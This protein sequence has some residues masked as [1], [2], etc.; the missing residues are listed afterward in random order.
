[1][2]EVPQAIGLVL[3][4]R[5]AALPEERDPPPHRAELPAHADG[6]RAG[7]RGAGAASARTSSRSGTARRT[8]QAGAPLPWA[9]V[10]VAAMAIFVIITRDFT[11]RQKQRVNTVSG[12][13]ALVANVAAQHRT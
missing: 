7:G 11:A 2:L 5:L 3:Y 1:M 12:L 8:P 13:L 10:G 4:P 9:A 6:D